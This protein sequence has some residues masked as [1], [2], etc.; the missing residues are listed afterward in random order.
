MQAFSQL[1]FRLLKVL[2]F[3]MV[4][5]PRQDPALLGCD[6]SL[7]QGALAVQSM[8]SLLKAFLLTALRGAHSTGYCLCCH[9]HVA[10]LLGDCS[11]LFSVVLINTMSKSHRGKRGF[12][13]LLRASPSLREPRQTVE[14]L[15]LMACSLYSL[16]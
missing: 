9:S 5:Q 14:E 1:K 15:C 3:V 8:F 4:E 12:G 13:S 2:A 6:K 10:P 16:T 11:S 7:S